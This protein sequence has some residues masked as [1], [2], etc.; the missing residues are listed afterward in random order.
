MESINILANLAGVDPVVVAL[1]IIWSL[2][3]KGL[4][5]WRSAELRQKYWFIAIFLI[6]TLG[7][8]EIIYYFLIAKRYKVEVV[9]KIIAEGETPL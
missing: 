2:A 6:N 4:A 3:W 8:L 7:I 9:E 5:L 1:A